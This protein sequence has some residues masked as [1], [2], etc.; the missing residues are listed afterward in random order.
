MACRRIDSGMAGTGVEGKGPARHPRPDSRHL[1]RGL[2]LHPAARL[3]M[4]LHCWEHHPMGGLASEEDRCVTWRQRWLPPLGRGIT[5]LHRM[6]AR[7]DAE[8]GGGPQP[9]GSP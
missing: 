2:G 4:V 8:P 6:D 9:L 7:T 5:T 1:S 3:V